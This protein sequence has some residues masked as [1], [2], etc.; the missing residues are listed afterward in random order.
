MIRR[1]PRSTLFPYT[2]LFR[3][4][5]AADQPP[6]VAEH[7]ELG[8]QQLLQVRLHTVLLQPR[9]N[10]EVHRGVADHLGDGDRD[11]L[12]GLVGDRPL[13]RLLGQPPPRPP[14]SHPLYPP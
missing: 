1:P 10:A 8:G 11:R 3:S 14:P 6:A 13:A 5:L 7:L 9:V 2:T 4:V 12:P